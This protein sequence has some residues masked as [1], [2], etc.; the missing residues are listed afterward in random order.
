[1]SRSEYRRTPRVQQSDTFWAQLS[2]PT[3]HGTCLALLLVVAVSFYAPMILGGKS[4]QS[5]DGV[6]WR[7][8]ANALIEHHE[9]TGEN[10]L[11]NP[12]VYSGMPAFMMN[13]KTEVPQLDDVA[14]TARSFAWPVSH[15]FFLLLGMYVLVYYLTR[16]SW[17]GMLSA[18]AFG[19]TT[20]LP[21]ILGAGHNTKFIALT[22]APYLLLA[23]VYALRNPT[24]L[25]G[26]FFAAALALNLRAKHPQITYSVLMLVLVWWVVELVFAWQEDEVV[27]FAK[28]TGWLALGTGTALLMVAQPYWAI[29]E[30][31]QY[32]VRGGGAI[33]AGGGAD[34]GGGMGWEKA[35]RWSQGPTELFTL[36]VADA[37][38]GGG[39]MYWGPKVFTAGPHYVGGIVAA[40]SG[41]ALWRGTRRTTW[42]IGAGVFVTVLF[43]LGKYV[44]WINGP[45]F[46]Y[47]PFFDAFRAPETWLSVSA[48]GLAV[49]AGF[50]FDYCL[51]RK[52]GRK[53]ESEKTWAMIYA[54]GGLAG[55]VC[56]LMV[57]KSVFFDFESKRERQVIQQI[58]RRPNLS[59][60]NPQ[61]RRFYQ[62]LDRR[63]EQRRDVFRADAIRTLLVVGIALLFLW[64]YRRERVPFWLAAGGVLLILVIDL[65]GVDRRYLGDDQLSSQSSTKAA[66]PTYDYDRFLNERAEDKGGTGPFRVFPWQT[67]R[68]QNPMNN[69]IP[70]YHHESVGG[71]HPAKLKRYQ[72]YIDYILQGGRGEAPSETALD[73]MNARYI[74]AQEKLPGTS[75]VYQSDDTKS[76]I[77]ENRDAVPRGFLVGQTD[78]IADPEET[79]RRLRSPSFDPRSTAL[80][81]EALEASV[82]PIDSGSTIS[83]S[84]ESYSLEEVTWT[85]QTDAP[86]LFV[87]S[88]IHYPAGWNAYLDGKQVPI[89]RVNYL[90]RGVHVPAGEHTLT[91]RFEPKAD[92]Y[93][94]L[95]AGGTTALVYGGILLLAARYRR[96]GGLHSL[97]ESEEQEET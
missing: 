82:T 71:A 5:S 30:Y 67:P 91:M 60:S 78:V 8:K 97:S 37:F 81:P 45:M 24:F 68:G 6:G 10:A 66:I 34:G 87:A 42:G 47:F 17:S 52:E 63:K 51:R 93:G 31:K 32:S 61:V 57:G 33:A 1:M 23:F 62:Q 13:Y 72:H 55:I 77:L 38:G 64:L 65:W 36:V 4:I 49:L 83:S 56:L 95:I 2:S 48:L 43:S 80:L 85:V 39:K 15:L 27:P 58:E 89:H 35:M 73:L 29:Y 7:A 46:E 25:S 88:E 90:L 22:F 41:L 59:R 54:F 16:N 92:R 11:W 12:N 75:V 70:S 20:Y 96:W 26:L 44:P 9:E 84:L 50:G 94:V 76:V 74:I 28:S 19:F 18:L 86:R 53:E 21:I 40:L 69:P 3:R 79:W 14:D